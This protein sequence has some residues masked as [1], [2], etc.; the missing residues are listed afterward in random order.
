MTAS[1]ESRLQKIS[2]SIPNHLNKAVQDILSLE[3]NR[4]STS[5]WEVHLAVEKAIKIIILQKGHDHYNKHNLIKL[6]NIA[7]NISGITLDCSIFSKLPSDNEAIQQRYGEGS[8]FSI[9]QAVKNY[10]Y[11]IEVI[12]ELTGKLKKEFIFNNARFHIRL[13]PW[14]K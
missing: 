3:S 12:S 9:Q 8:S 4:I 13:P 11:A 14:L 10:T 1:L 7:N 2:S 5:Y 6:C